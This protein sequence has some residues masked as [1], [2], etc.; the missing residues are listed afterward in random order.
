MA[1]SGGWGMTG[2]GRL[3]L[4]ENQESQ[5]TVVIQQLIGTRWTSRKQEGSRSFRSGE[6]DTK[7]GARANDKPTLTHQR[8]NKAR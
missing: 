3:K 4:L 6:L 5:N 1:W 7:K 8:P 2:M